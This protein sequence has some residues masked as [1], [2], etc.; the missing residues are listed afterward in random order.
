MQKRQGAWPLPGKSGRQTCII[1]DAGDMLPHCHPMR[2]M[3]SL[4]SKLKVLY[5][6]R[7]LS[8][9]TWIT[10]RFCQRT[11]LGPQTG[12]NARS[13]RQMNTTANWCVALVSLSCNQMDM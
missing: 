6:C 2:A 8:T 3:L 10:F 12:P 4:M 9:W 1:T 5:L 7:T 13:H 11:M